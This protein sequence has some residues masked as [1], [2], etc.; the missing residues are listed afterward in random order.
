MNKVSALTGH[1][2]LSISSVSAQ[3]FTL[4][5]FSALIFERIKSSSLFGLAMDSIILKN[6]G[7]AAILPVNVP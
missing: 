1:I 5:I 7:A 4:V 2:S 3:T 6:K